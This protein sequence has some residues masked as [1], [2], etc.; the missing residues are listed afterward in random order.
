MP[1]KTFNEQ[2]NA[3]SL[4]LHALQKMRQ[5][6][7]LPE[8]VRAL[9]EEAGRLSGALRTGVFL[10]DESKSALLLFASW[11]PDKGAVDE[12]Q[13]AVPVSLDA[14]PLCYSLQMGKPYH[15]RVDLSETLALFGSP[16]G[17]SAAF[18]LLACGNATLGGVL[19]ELP[20]E[21]GHEDLCKAEMVCAYAAMLFEAFLQKKRDSSLLQTLRDDLA[22]IEEQRSNERS[23][24]LARIMGESAG[25]R[26]VREL[27][28]KV[29]PTEASLLITGET[30]TGKELV[31]DAVHALSRRRSAPLVKINCA[32]I[33]A[34]L[35]ESELF[36][37][38]KGAFSGAVSDQKGLLRSADGGTVLLDEVGDMPMELQAKLLRFLQEQEIRPLG[39]VRSYPVSIR[40]LASTN[41]KLQE[42]MHAGEFRRDLYHRLAA[43]QIH[44]PPLRDR[45]EDILLLASHFLHRFALEYK[46]SAFGFSPESLLTLSSYSFPGNVRELINIIESAIVASDGQSGLLPIASPSAGQGQAQGWKLDLKAHLD[47]ME[48][49]II[50]HTLARFNGNT[51]KAAG[52]LGL[53]RSTL[54][55]KLRKGPVMETLA[56]L[57]QNDDSPADMTGRRRH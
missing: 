7:D 50:A 17:Y 49:S 48:Q 28:L 2:G 41:K 10:L 25:I 53:P 15:A 14:D 37:H 45:Q 30:G 44:I 20:E 47:K 32:A 55:S 12:A 6:A 52:A 27:I 5:C 3:S 54:T 46:R 33:P 18:P 36:G 8:A 35:L 21:P 26:Q 51:S 1:L 31:A 24:I 57:L 39:D 13:Q 29:A 22:G 16:S 23:P 42:A 11:S 43:F 40:I 56:H 4:L 38:K 19:A 34:Q 9:A